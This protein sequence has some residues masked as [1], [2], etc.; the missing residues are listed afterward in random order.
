MEVGTTSIKFADQYSVIAAGLASFNEAIAALNEKV[1][2]KDLSRAER[3]A[4]Q[5]QI[6]RIRLKMT[7]INVRLSVL[8]KEAEKAGIVF[9]AQPE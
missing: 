2:R 8:K 6:N 1:Q 9:D 5:S 7:S 4:A 3:R